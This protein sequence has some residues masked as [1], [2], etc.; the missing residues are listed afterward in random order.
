MHPD[1]VRVLD[2]ELPAPG[3]TAGLPR[4]CDGSDSRPS[5]AV[6]NPERVGTVPE[7]RGLV[8]ADGSARARS[9]GLLRLG[10][11]LCGGAEGPPKG[12][13][14]PQMYRPKFTRDVLTVARRTTGRSSKLRRLHR[15]L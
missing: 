9:S 1:A 6:D 15:S 10:R 3:L 13:S 4:Q 12:G 11:L 2:V 14:A 8:N 5:P 7:D